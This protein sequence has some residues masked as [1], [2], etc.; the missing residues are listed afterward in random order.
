MSAMPQHFLLLYDLPISISGWKEPVLFFVTSH[1][2]IAGG[3]TDNEFVYKQ[4]QTIRVLV[5]L[6]P[7]PPARLC[8]YYNSLLCTRRQDGTWA[9]ILSMTDRLSFKSIPIS[10]AIVSWFMVH[11]FSV[12]GSA[13]VFLGHHRPSSIHRPGSWAGSIPVFSTVHN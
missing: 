11:Q 13:Q 8:T 7:G 10:M 9:W 2:T 5:V 3:R 1:R 12:Q 4:E 6:L